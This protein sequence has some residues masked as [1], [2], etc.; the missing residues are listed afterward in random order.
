[1]AN[2]SGNAT[3]YKEVSDAIKRNPP[4]VADL[5]VLKTLCIAVDA[6]N[7]PGVSKPLKD[8]L[9]LSGFE[10]P[11]H[12]ISYE[13]FHALL[14][15]MLL[16][17]WF[18]EFELLIAFRQSLFGTQDGR[19]ADNWGGIVKMVNEKPQSL[20]LLSRSNHEQEWKRA[21]NGLEG[22]IRHFAEV[23]LPQPTYGAPPIEP[24]YY[25]RV[26]PEALRDAIEQFFRVLQMLFQ[27]IL[28]LALADLGKDANNT[29]RLRKL[30]SLQETL[31]KVLEGKDKPPGLTPPVER[32]KRVLNQ[33]IRVAEVRYGGR[34]KQHRFFDAFPRHDARSVI[35]TS[36]DRED[37]DE[38]YVRGEKIKS[39]H[40]LRDR[41][42]RFHLTT[43]GHPLDS[44]ARP[45]A[46]HLRRRA[47][48]KSKHGGQL[49]LSD[50][51]DVV[52]FLS[53]VFDDRLDELT[54]GKSTT[55]R[56]DASVRAWRETVELG[57]A[58]F[59]Q[60]TSH[61]RLNL[62]EGPPN[63]LTHVFPRNIAGRLFHDCGVYAV[64]G[65]YTLLSLFDEMNRAHAN[66]VGTVR[67]RWVRLPLHVGVMIE[68]SN[69][70]LL[71]QHNEHLFPIDQ[72]NL[73]KVRQEWLDNRPPTETDP[74][75]SDAVTLKFYEDIAASAFSSDLD[76]P[77]NSTPLLGPGEAVTTQSIWNSYQKKVVPSQLFTNLVGSPNAPQYQFDTR[78]L[79][80][81]ETE[82]EWYNKRVLPFWNDVCH[83][84]WIRWQKSLTNS[85]STKLADNKQAYTEE[86]LEA[87]EIMLNS[88][89]DELKPEKKR[90]SKDLRA[91]GKLLL[92]DVRTV[93]AARISTILAPVT[94]IKDHIGEV[95]DPA[96][97]FHSHFAPP[98]AKPNEKLLEIP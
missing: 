72:H 10:D 64:R 38:P 81:S 98:F 87:T 47:L 26:L 7:K 83:A 16:K 82:R 11:L 45:D 35:F 73:Q 49:K 94:K 36:L 59:G 52:E 69:F 9:Q 54:R 18:N 37:K 20:G 63:Y 84:I 32:I 95:S 93:T 97:K 4:D 85:Q 42:L 92:R 80:I 17:G 8:L 5:V 53:A 56:A 79:Q 6:D 48:I 15:R 33:T 76:M 30:Q 13:L 86:L 21:L 50:H 62:T 89:R 46:W 23:R 90:L 55:V 88:Y 65:A 71:V 78:Y 22:A 75:D 39:I 1:M 70:G 28:E 31:E 43:Y 44:R 14:A 58:Y 96:F 24:A 29:G 57:S 66:V 91:D 74:S 25:E 12:S 2:G 67:A 41:Q 27:Q 68:C 34:G 19:V 40:V 60:L 77:I 3:F 61:S 51:D